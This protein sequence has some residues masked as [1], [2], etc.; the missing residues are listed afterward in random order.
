MSSKINWKKDPELKKIIEHEGADYFE[1]EEYIDGD[2]IPEKIVKE[3]LEK[4]YA[5]D[6]TFAESFEFYYLI[7]SI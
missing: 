1:A 6:E 2:Y 4:K 5:E 7:R 3:V